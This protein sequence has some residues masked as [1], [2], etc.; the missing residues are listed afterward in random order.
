MTKLWT[1]TWA[2]LV[3][4]LIL[5]G[6][7][8]LDPGPVQRLRLLN[9]DGYQHLLTE[10]V[11]ENIVLYDIDE[12]FLKEHGQWPPRRDVLGQL[13]EDLYT[14]G[15]ALVVLIFYSLKKI[16]LVATMTS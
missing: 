13:V 2:V 14:Q 12:A 1:S 3:F 8:Y 6:V 7:R 10:T 15:A 9:F 11:S 16:D 5:T 4:L